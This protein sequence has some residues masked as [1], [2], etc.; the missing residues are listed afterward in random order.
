MLEADAITVRRGGT[1]VLTGCSVRVDPGQITAIIGPNGCG[2]S[3]LLRALTGIQSVAAGTVRLDGRDIAGQSRR[4]IAR[5][6]A[7]LPQSPQAPTGLRVRQ[8]V[9]HGRFAHGHPFAGLSRADHAAVDAAL[10]H[11]QTSDWANRA[12]DSLSGGERQRVWLALA[13]AQA[14]RLLMLDEPT[15]YL[16]IGH[17]ESLLRLLTKLHGQS[18]QGLV[19][20]LHDLNQ[21]SRFA[22]RVIVMQ[23]GQIIA[24]GP[25]AD[26]LCPRMIQRLYDID[27]SRHQ[28]ATGAQVFLPFKLASG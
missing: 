6:V 21:A 15:S 28:S 7:L 27:L 20:V 22:D 17:Q 10:A 19:M 11:T 13:L 25:P 26:A 24:D 1:Q 14:P 18:G 23:Q 8:L 9:E 16:D 12:F 4:T 3:T 5:V 2:K